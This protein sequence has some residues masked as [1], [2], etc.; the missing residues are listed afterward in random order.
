[1]V[2]FKCHVNHENLYLT[3]SLDVEE[4]KVNY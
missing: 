2:L 1:M 3:T 4:Y